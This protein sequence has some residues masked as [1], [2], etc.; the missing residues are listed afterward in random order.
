M[1]LY[2]LEGFAQSIPDGLPVAGS[3]VIPCKRT[4]ASAST[5]SFRKGEY[6]RNLLLDPQLYLTGLEAARCAARCS[7]LATWEWFP[8]GELQKEKTGR[9]RT[10]QKWMK[11]SKKIIGKYWTGELPAATAADAAVRDVARAQQEIGCESIILASPLTVNPNS[12]Y[13]LE[14]EW[15]DRGLRAARQ[16]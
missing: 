10:T 11:K 15:L 4:K 14:L 7:A 9:T 3:I 6:R 8:T 2:G 16:G 13:S 1:A 5:R 12:D